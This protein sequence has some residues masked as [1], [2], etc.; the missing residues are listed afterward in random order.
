MAVAA[1][2]HGADTGIPHQPRWLHAVVS[3][4]QVV[5]GAL[6]YATPGEALDLFRRFADRVPAPVNPSQTA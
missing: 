6:P 2:L 5:L 1:H 3:D 4:L